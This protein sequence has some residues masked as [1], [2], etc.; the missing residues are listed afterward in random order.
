[1]AHSCGIKQWVADGHVAVIGHHSQKIVVCV[2]ESHV[3]IHLHQTTTIGNSP[4]LEE[5]VLQ[6]L[7]DSHRGKTHIC[8]RKIP[9]EEIHG[10]LQKVSI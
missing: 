1:M 9:E 7:G 3:E 5:K 4:D 6:H 10:G 8:Q 2:G